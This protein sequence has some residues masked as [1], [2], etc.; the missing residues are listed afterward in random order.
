M[1]KI[2]LFN[3]KKGQENQITKIRKQRG[4]ITTN[5]IEIKKIIT[6][7]YYELLCANKLSNLDEMDKFLDCKN[8][9]VDPQIYMEIQGT[10]NSPNNVRRTKLEELYFPIST[11]LPE[12]KI[13]LW[14]LNLSYFWTFNKDCVI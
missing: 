5:C 2:N 14:D 8:W 6:S 13:V 12:N 7:D 10:Q 11:I 9:Q 3:R 4:D 1:W